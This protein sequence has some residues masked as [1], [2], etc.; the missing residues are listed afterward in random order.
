MNE[1]QNFKQKNGNEEN[2]FDRIA[3]H[4]DDFGRCLLKDMHANKMPIIEA[5]HGTVQK[6]VR[7]IF[8]D[9][10]QGMKC[11]SCHYIIY[12]CVH[13]VILVSGFHTGFYCGGGGRSL[14]GSVCGLGSTHALACVQARGVWGLLTQSETKFPTIILMTH[15]C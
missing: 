10:L 7:Q 1:L 11:M 6:K 13:R 4:Y 2:L 8:T 5:N 14:W 9:W 3:P 15:R 12:G